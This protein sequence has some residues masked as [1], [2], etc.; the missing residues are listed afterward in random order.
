M[1]RR[2]RIDQQVG[3][4]DHMGGVQANQADSLGGYGHG[5]VPLHWADRVDGRLAAWAGRSRIAVNAVS[6]PPR[7]SGWPLD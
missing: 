7:T 3:E 6:V 5:S 4:A 1:M 2:F